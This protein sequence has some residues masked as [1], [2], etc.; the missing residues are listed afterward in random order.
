MKKF[1]KFL[2]FVFIC[3]LV[4]NS[5]LVL[6]DDNRSKKEIKLHELPI[7]IKNSK[8]IKYNLKLYLYLY[9]SRSKFS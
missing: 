2:F 5:H 1:I 6:S 4:S 8:T 3:G 7:K 9:R